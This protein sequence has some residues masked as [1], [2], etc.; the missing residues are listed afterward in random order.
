MSDYKNLLGK[1]VKFFTSDLS[2]AD[3]EGQIFYSDTDKEYKVGVLGAGYKKL[4]IG[5]KPPILEVHLMVL[6]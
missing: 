3:S 2:T 4:F 1:K 6:L 5:I